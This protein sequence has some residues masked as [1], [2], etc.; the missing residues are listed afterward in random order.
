MCDR[1]V[2]Y[3]Y[4][5]MRTRGLLENTLLIVTTDHGHSLGDEGYLGKQAYPSEPNVFEIAFIVRHPESLGTGR[6]TD[7]IV[8]HTDIP[9]TVLDIA[10]VQPAQP[11]EGSSFLG[12][13]SGGG[14]SI[15][16]HA[17]VGWGSAVT[18]VNDRWWLNLKV[19][20]TGPFLYDLR[21]EE[22]REN[23]LADEHP[24]IV[25][26]MFAQAV[27]DAQGGFPDY[28]LELARS[29]SDAPGCSELAARPA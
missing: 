9:A 12:M 27:N 6:T 20:A 25:S 29:Q 7:A 23:N 18:V 2:G 19:D 14:A 13:L 22:P 17:T 10:G 15:R 21:A 28:L 16:D 11:M 8:Q 3:L 26:R 4:E 24:D 1:W 5:A